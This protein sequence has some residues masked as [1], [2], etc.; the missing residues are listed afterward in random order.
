M[1]ASTTA[2]TAESAGTSHGRRMENG[3][4]LQPR[5]RAELRQVRPDRAAQSQARI[6]VGES[7]SARIEPST[8]KLRLVTSIIA[9][10]REWIGVGT[11]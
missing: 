3:S 9:L 4:T 5:L 2:A 7:E 10:P 6:I 8:L 11:A 1:T